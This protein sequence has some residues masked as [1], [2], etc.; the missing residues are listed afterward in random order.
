MELQE[1]KTKNAEI[2]ME[3]NVNLL[4]KTEE[5]KKL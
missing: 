5:I 1:I 2:V 3:L 4:S